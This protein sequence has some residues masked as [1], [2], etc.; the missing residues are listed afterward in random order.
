MVVA[1]FVFSA[2]ALL[3]SGA[4][5]GWQLLSWF[6][7]GG[8]IVVT[9]STGVVGHGG[10]TH[11]PRL[12]KKVLDQLRAQGHT[13]PVVCVIEV[14]NRGRT[15]VYIQ[16]VGIAAGPMT[17]L[18]FKPIHGPNLPCK[19]EPG[20]PLTWAIHSREALNMR[21]L[22]VQANAAPDVKAFAQ[23]GTGKKRYTK[24]AMD[25]G[26]L[27]ENGERASGK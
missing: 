14:H 4:A 3:L 18:V 9:I 8:R 15:P 16:Q 26:A 11:I 19:V 6:L 7:N 24:Q 12:T 17:Y 10:I 25:V 2:V 1:S 13:G 5:F 21:A 20:Q 22:A 23:L 27:L